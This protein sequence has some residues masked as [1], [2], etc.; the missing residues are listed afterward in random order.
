M[1]PRDLD[2]LTPYLV[3]VGTVLLYCGE[4]VP[5]GF[6]ECDG[7]TPNRLDYPNLFA[8]L[9]TTFG[10]GDGA[11]TFGLPDLRGRAPIGAGLGD[12]LTTRDLGDTLGAEEGCCP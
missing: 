4:L 5:P 2:K 1:T 10:R 6:L 9:G 12:N 3:P 7:S 11:T 8:I